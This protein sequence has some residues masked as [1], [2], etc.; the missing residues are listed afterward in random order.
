[1]GQQNYNQQAVNGPTMMNNYQGGMGVR[2]E[3]PVFNPRGPGRGGSQDDFSH[4]F[5]IYIIT[6]CYIRI[7]IT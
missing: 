6:P 5:H 7:I 2:H 1:M 3:E 4:V